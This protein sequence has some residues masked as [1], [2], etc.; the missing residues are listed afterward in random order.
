MT[1]KLQS[2]D[3]HVD[4][5]ARKSANR[6]MCTL[7]PLLSELNLI[8]FSN[9]VNKNTIG[10]SRVL[11]SGQIRG[12]F[13]NAPNNCDKSPISLRGYIAET[14]IRSHFECAKIMK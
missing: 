11:A 5:S 12:A 6:M 13:C 7:G 1:K 3:S 14:E 8:Q 9:L 10:V 2:G 4:T